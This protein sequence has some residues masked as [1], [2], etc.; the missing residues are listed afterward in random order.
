MR[1]A[2][3]V[4]FVIGAAAGAVLVSGTGVVAQEGRGKSSGQIETLR[5]DMEKMV[6]AQKKLVDEV[7]ELRSSFERHSHP[8][9]WWNPKEG[10]STSWTG[11]TFFIAYPKVGVGDSD[12]DAARAGGTWGTP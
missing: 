12:A 9:K 10:A 11:G 8:V 1:G 4:A 5:A 3:F 6:V 7:K 2:L